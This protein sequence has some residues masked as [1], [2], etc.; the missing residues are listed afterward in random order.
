MNLATQIFG[1]VGG[2]PNIMQISS[3]MTRLRLTLKDAS[4]IDLAQLKAMTGV[5]GVIAAGEQLQIVIGP[6]KVKTVASEL[7]KLLAEEPGKTSQPA[8]PFPA[9]GEAAATKAAVAAKNSTPLKRNLARLSAVFVPLI[10]A[11]VASGMVAGLTNVAVR[12]GVDPQNSL[13]QILN[14]IGWGIF[15]YLAIFIGFQAAREFGG[16]PALGGLAG[17]LLINPAISTL[18][19]D[20]QYLIPGRGGVFG[21][22]LVAGLM[23]WL[24][25]RI[26]RY[27]PSTVDIILTP[28][29]TLLAGGFAAYYVLQPLSGLLSDGVVWFFRSLLETGGVVAGMI[30][31]GTFLPLVL[32]GLHQG[33]TPVHMELLQTLRANP[34]LPVL[35]MAGAG[36]VGASLAVLLKTRNRRLK[37]IIKAALP[38]G[39]LGIGEPLIFGVTLPLGRPFL[40]ACAGAAVGGAFQAMMHV[41]SISMGVSGLPL[42]F[43]IRSDQI[44]WY[45][46]GLFIAYVAG[47]AVTWAVGF[48]DPA[49]Q[50]QDKETA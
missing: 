38:V 50:E 32:T 14:V 45:L 36:Q 7:E 34:L 39:L 43:L 24:E 11:I 33:L 42:S 3:C 44:A 9:L 21:V 15:G 31:A 28:T 4:G 23:V 27:M 35:A 48:A 47:F 16:T 13:L 1:A 6:G 10:P 20:G 5:I 30:L 41:E 37:K 12:L 19:I 49:E 26:R 17:V 29:L 25:K 2:R 40:T 22:L 18:Q 8:T 46:T